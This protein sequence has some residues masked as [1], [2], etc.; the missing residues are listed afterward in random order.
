VGVDVGGLLE[1]K[2][3]RGA[4]PVGDAGGHVEALFV[5]LGKGGREIQEVVAA[6]FDGAAEFSL[7]DARAEAY[8]GARR[9]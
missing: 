7:G 1:L 9:K 8:V 3:E 5:S 4:R 2:S 6:A